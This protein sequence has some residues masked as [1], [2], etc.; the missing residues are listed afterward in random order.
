MSK[1]VG[2][3][4]Q[5]GAEKQEAPVTLTKSACSQQN[6]FK[7]LELEHL[8]FQN[9]SAKHKFKM[10][11]VNNNKVFQLDIAV[12]FK[13]NTI[14]TIFVFSEGGNVIISDCSFCIGDED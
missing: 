2:G 8:L 4:S 14:K 1:R 7:H 9:F 13:F 10:Q 3:D 5:K 12:L 11:K 6:T